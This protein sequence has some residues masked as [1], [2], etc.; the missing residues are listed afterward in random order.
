MSKGTKTVFRLLVLAFVMFFSQGVHRAYGA[1]AKQHVNDSITVSLLTCSP[2]DLIYELYGHTALRITDHTCKQDVIFNYGVFDFSQPHFIWRFMLGKTDYMVQ[3]LPFTLFEMEYVDRGSSIMSQTLNLTRVEANQLYNSLL[4]DAL[5]ENRVYRYNFL[6]CNCTTQVRDMIESAIH[7]KVHYKEQ[8]KKTYRES[9]H[10]YTAGSPWAELGDDILLGANTDTLLS[11]RSAQFL[12]D[13]LMS[14]FSQAMIFDSVCN[15]RPLVL[16]DAVMLLE[17]REMPK[18]DGFPLSPFV[19][20]LI[21]VGILLLVAA[22][23][24]WLKRLFWVFDLLFMPCVGV[25]GLLVTFMF[26]FSEHPTVD[27]NWQIWVLNPLPLFCMPWVVWCAIKRRRCA[28]HYANAVILALFLIAMPWIPQHFSVIT[29]PLALG[30]LT[31][32]VSYIINFNRLKPKKKKPS[33]KKK[34]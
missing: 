18:P 6:T 17:P 4:E 12:P 32:P 1:P 25:M 11:D 9:L 30:L 27:S 34:K 23:E 5:P 29:L 15:S 24:Y 21:F 8:P 2:G 14:Y 13:Y 28:Y 16:G 31:R 7:G 33:R 22:L 3:P 20:S 19:C 26:L 10:E